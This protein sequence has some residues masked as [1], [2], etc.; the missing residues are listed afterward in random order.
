MPY[1]TSNG[2]R[3][4]YEEAGKGTALVDGGRWRPRD[5]RSLGKS[6]KA[7]KA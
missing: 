4:Y 1:A 3:L 7:R 2:V 5:P 6:T